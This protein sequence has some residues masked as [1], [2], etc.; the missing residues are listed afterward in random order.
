MNINPYTPPQC[1]LSPSTRMLVAHSNFGLVAALLSCSSGVCVAYAT[2][3]M[4]IAAACSLAFLALQ[5]SITSAACYIV[6]RLAPQ[7]DAPMDHR[8]VAMPEPR[9]QSRSCTATAAGFALPQVLWCI[10]AIIGA[11]ALLLLLHFIAFAVF[12]AAEPK[13]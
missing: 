1:S 4:L 10:S 11:H 13:W 5:A 12:G 8:K 6:A 2:N 3:D 9:H 7:D